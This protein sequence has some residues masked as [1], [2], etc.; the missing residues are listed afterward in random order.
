MR[1]STKRLM[2]KAVS[3]IVLF[4]LLLLN[5]NW[6]LAKS[7]NSFPQT[8]SNASSSSNIPTGLANPTYSLLG[9]NYL[10][11]PNDVLKI[12]IY[13]SEDLSRGVRV[14]GDGYISLPLIGSIIASGLSVADLEFVIAHEY[15]KK[16]LQNPQVSINVEEFVSKKVIIMGEV[17]SPQVLRLPANSINLI[18]ILSLCGGITQDA[19]DLIYILRPSEQYNGLNGSTNYGN[20]VHSSNQKRDNYRTEDNFTEEDYLRIKNEVITVKISELVKYHNPASNMEILPGDT[21]S[22]PAAPFYFVFGEIAKPGAFKL[23]AG[24]T[25]MRAIAQAGKLSP[26]AKTKIKLLRDDA[27]S[28]EKTIATI[29]FKDL[30]KGKL[31]DIEIQGGDILVVGKSTLKTI[32][33]QILAFSQTTASAVQGV[34]ITD[35]VRG[36]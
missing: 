27:E 12:D 24:M 11:G 1:D 34:M 20:V 3:L 30:V 22:I 9:K 28:G 10:I 18:E 2:P 8:S 29:N 31:D 35:V 17:R 16:Y 15:S 32:G 21:I 4:C 36:D 26:T 23:M 7:I 33:H 5:G 19:G 13:D 14:G 6:T 25:A